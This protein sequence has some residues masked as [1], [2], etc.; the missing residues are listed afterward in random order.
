M[1]SSV[2]SMGEYLGALSCRPLP[3]AVP[4]AAHD[5]SVA[6]RQRRPPCAQTR[7]NEP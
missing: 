7:R 1:D 3:A 5:R 2:L 6:V 4:P